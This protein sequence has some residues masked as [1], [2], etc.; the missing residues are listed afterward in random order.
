MKKRYLIFAAAAFVALTAGCNRL[1]MVGMFIN[2]SDTEERV[3]DWLNYNEQFGEPVFENV[4]DNYR[5]YSC[6]DSHYSDR[7]DVTPQGENDRVFNFVT[8]ERNDSCAVFSIIAGDLANESG[9]TPYIMIEN[10]IRY[11]AERQ[12][13]N[14]PCFPIVGNHDV[15]Y[16]CAKFY[17]QHFHTSTYSVT[18]KTVGGHQ[19][20]F[21]FLDSGNG[22]HGKRQMDWLEDKL[23]HRDEY[24]NCVVVSHCWLFRTS[25]NYT[26]TP[27]ANLPEDEQYAFMDLMS[28]NNVSLV[29]MGHFHACEQRQFNGV[30]YVMIDNLNEETDAPSYL[31][32]NC[33]EKVSFEYMN[34]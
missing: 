12:I 18:V 24:R 3:N 11:N 32:L 15:Y 17:K 2:R 23:S 31:I 5:V 7:D 16:D 28:D 33:G 34:L 10:S 30:T 8:A 6:S 29:V 21:L 1:D 14:D 27:A 9:E 25:Y 19:D 26:T 22:T 13:K 4:P 20:L